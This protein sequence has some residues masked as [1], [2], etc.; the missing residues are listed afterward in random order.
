[1]YI[2]DYHNLEPKSKERPDITP[3]PVILKECFH[4]SLSPHYLGVFLGTRGKHVKPRC[5][6]YKVQMHL[7]EEDGESGRRRQRHRQ[8]GSDGVVKVTVSYKPEDKANVREFKEQLAK[9]ALAVTRSRDKHQEN[10]NM[11]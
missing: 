4:L 10:V 5:L 9:R 11:Y 6:K 1:M 2:G 8:H 7:G 3:E